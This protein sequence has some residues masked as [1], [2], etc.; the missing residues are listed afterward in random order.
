[1]TRCE[2][3]RA[4]FRETEERSTVGSRH[5]VSTIGERSRNQNESSPPN[6]PLHSEFCDGRAVRLGGLH[7]PNLYC[8]FVLNLTWGAFIITRRQ[9]QSGILWL[10]WSS[11]A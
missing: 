11:L 6:R 10:H 8:L 1:M 4:F 7:Y 5:R 9:W 3:R 2:S